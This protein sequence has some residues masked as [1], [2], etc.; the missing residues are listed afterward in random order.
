MTHLTIENVITYL[1]GKATD[2]EKELGL[3]KQE[4]VGL[5][6]YFF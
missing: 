5:V 2:A 1:D 3:S 6:D 4:A